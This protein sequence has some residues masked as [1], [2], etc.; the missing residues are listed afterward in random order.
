MA[1]ALHWS[2]NSDS[3]RTHEL[4]IDYLTIFIQAVIASATAWVPGSSI[5][6]FAEESWKLSQVN[7][8]ALQNH[9]REI[10]LATYYQVVAEQILEAQQEANRRK[11]LY[12]RLLARGAKKLLADRK[13]Y[14]AASPWLG[15]VAPRV[16]FDAASKYTFEGAEGSVERNT[17]KLLL[18]LKGTGEFTRRKLGDGV[19]ELF[20][21]I[22]VDKEGATSFSKLIGSGGY[23]PSTSEALSAWT[24]PEVEE[25]LTR[26]F[27]LKALDATFRSQEIW[28]TCTKEFKTVKPRADSTSIAKYPTNICHK[29][30]SGPQDLKECVDGHVC[31]MYKWMSRSNSYSNHRVEYPF[32]MQD[33]RDAPYDVDPKDVIY[34]SVMTYMEQHKKDAAPP[35]PL[36]L[37]S[38][39]DATSSKKVWDARQPGFFTVPVCMSQYN[40]NTPIEPTGKTSC[41]LGSD[42]RHRTLP[43][44][45]GPY[46][47]ETKSLWKDVGLW[48]LSAAK[49]Y[50]KE[51]CSRQIR[52]RIEDNLEKYTAHCGIGIRN[53]GI[54]RKKAIG[55][56]VMC[57]PILEQLREADYPPLATMSPTLRTRLLC[58][59]GKI[60]KKKCAQFGS[61]IGPA[62][63]QI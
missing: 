16:A 4:L 40:F 34:S 17:E 56:N 41:F 32:G 57:G 3:E 6:T 7:V 29:D 27:M 52:E 53:Q 43:C 28:I 21:G 2:E 47:S 63:R 61:L 23:L 39:K 42:C 10:E 8:D 60:N 25:K 46:G 5:L 24:G 18:Y 45:C 50:R 13:W 1:K 9:I 31:Y 55:A 33:I 19:D 11:E 20:K 38:F 51:H 54:A 22:D 35:R 36:S 44:N 49:N 37:A 15:I 48:D 58:L 14:Q 30:M 26:N 62:N 59:A 12:D